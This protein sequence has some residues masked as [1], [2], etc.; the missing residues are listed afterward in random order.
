MA[1]LGKCL[2]DTRTKHPETHWKVAQIPQG[3]PKLIRTNSRNQQLHN[4]DAECQD[5]IQD[6]VGPIVILFIC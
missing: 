1:Q 6:L 2:R 5:F 3:S 4:E